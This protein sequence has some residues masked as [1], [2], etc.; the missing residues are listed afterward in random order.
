[1]AAIGRQ[2]NPRKVY[3]FAVEV[4]GLDTAYAQKVKLPK[5]EVASAKH[6]DGPFTINTASRINFGQLE[7]E[8]LKPSESAAVWWKDW[9]ALIVNLQSGAM[10]TPELYKK[11]ISIVEY[12]ADGITIVE[13]HELWGVYPADIDLADLDK[14]GEGNAIDKLKFNVDRYI[15]TSGSVSVSGGVS[16][17]GMNIGSTV[18]L[19]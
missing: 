9:L 11:N 16:S 5:F 4:D 13:R 8:T 14:L 7:M 18:V 12:S 10:S 6:G 2:I 17:N 3:R 19:S 1:M 15:P